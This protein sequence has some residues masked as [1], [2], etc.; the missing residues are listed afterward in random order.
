MSVHQQPRPVVSSRLPSA[1][2]DTSLAQRAARPLAVLRI[3]T[4]FIFLWAFLDKTF[5]LGYATSSELAWINGG[6]PAAGYL[7]SVQAGPLE[8]TY[9]AWAGA[10]WVDWMYMAGM[11]GLG[12]ALIAGIGLR[13]TAVAGGAM[14]LLLW[15]G[16]WPVARY[17]SDG[18]PSM[19][20]NPL[21][22]QHIVYAGVMVLVALCSAGHTW[23]LGQAWARTP[24]VSRYRW[25]R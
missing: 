15:G 8:S 7:E 9:Q 24:L 5:G 4:G 19:S 22:D 25:L 12:L 1:G 17:L 10:V 20:A 18:S 3:V 16:Q 11:L 2:P 23:G 21:V 6:S 14:M 13:I